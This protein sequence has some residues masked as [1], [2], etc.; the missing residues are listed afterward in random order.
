MSVLEL[1]VS[2]MSS[3]STSA[4]VAHVAAAASPSPDVT[5]RASRA[6][7]AR[8][9]ALSGP[10]SD[11]RSGVML[12]VSVLWAMRHLLSPDRPQR[13]S[14]NPRGKHNLVSPSLRARP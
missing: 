11:R 12:S 1:T 6:S 3:P 2:A 5:A 10:I 14:R 7:N 13:A 9:A 4:G 8:T